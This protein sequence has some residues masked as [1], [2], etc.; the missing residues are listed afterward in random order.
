MEQ[1]RLQYLTISK[2]GSGIFRVSRAMSNNVLYYTNFFNVLT[3][4]KLQIDHDFY[5]RII[6]EA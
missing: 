4:L 3:C 2:I 6:Q 1:T 5:T